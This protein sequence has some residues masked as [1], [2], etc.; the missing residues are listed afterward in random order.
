MAIDTGKDGAVYGIGCARYWG[1]IDTSDDPTVFC[2]ASAGGPVMAD[3]NTDW[4]VEVGA[5]GH[6]PAYNP[7]DAYAF[8][9]DT[10]SASIQA[11]D[12]RRITAL[13]LAC[14]L[15]R[16]SESAHNGGTGLRFPSIV[17]DGRAT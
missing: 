9:G 13:L 2:S 1:V 17:T 15:G 5:Y 3:G 6:T 7:N 16:Q 10:A 4:R 11:K 12:I 8:I 14:E